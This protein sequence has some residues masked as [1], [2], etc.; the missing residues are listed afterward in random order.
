MCRYT[1]LSGLLG[2]NDYRNLLQ[3]ITLSASGDSSETHAS[4]CC[5]NYLYCVNCKL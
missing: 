2:R 1:S 4:H 3:S 5:L